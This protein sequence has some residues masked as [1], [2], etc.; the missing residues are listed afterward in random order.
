MG[1]AWAE[2][3]LDAAHRIINGAYA[4]AWIWAGRPLPGDA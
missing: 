4:S 1:L 2:L 3:P